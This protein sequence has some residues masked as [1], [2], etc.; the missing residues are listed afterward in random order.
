MTFHNCLNYAMTTDMIK[1][2]SYQ[3]SHLLS[4]LFYYTSAVLHD[5]WNLTNYIYV[6]AVCKYGILDTAVFT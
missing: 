3:L 6:Y 4:L 5:I 2:C 1:L